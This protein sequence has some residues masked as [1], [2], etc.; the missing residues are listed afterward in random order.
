MRRNSG[1]RCRY[2]GGDP[3]TFSSR[4]SRLQP[5]LAGR[6]LDR[7][8]LTPPGPVA[9]CLGACQ[10]HPEHR[11]W[12]R[13][14]GSTPDPTCPAGA[15][16]ALGPMRSPRGCGQSPETRALSRKPE[17]KKQRFRLAF[18]PMSPAGAETSGGLPGTFTEPSP[19][20]GGGGGG[21]GQ[22]MTAHSM[23]NEAEAQRLKRLPRQKLRHPLYRKPCLWNPAL[24]FF[25]FLI[26]G[27]F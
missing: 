14:R 12:E 23:H 2:I 20:S 6:F 7:R 24:F 25:S 13:Q 11:A 26:K 21:G 16:K 8:F 22:R 27:C 4:G 10:P 18:V 3:V 19:V 9:G 5:L 15:G 1:C 17:P